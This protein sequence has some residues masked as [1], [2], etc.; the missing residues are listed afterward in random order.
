MSGTKPG[1]QTEDLTRLAPKTPL[2]I[3]AK[4]KGH[5]RRTTFS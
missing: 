5:A 1:L 3:R 2:K 4:H